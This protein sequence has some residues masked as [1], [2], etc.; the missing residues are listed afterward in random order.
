MDTAATAPGVI[1]AAKTAYVTPSDVEQL[2]GCSQSRA[3]KA[4]RDV[5]SY[6]KKNGLFVFPQ[7]R[8]NKYTFSEKFG[9]PIE[10]INSVI[11]KE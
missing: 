10:I 11:N 2:L 7:G 5:N 3:Y 9:I 1:G 4:I 8:A 6:A